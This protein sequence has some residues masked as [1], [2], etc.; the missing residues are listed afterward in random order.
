MVLIVQDT[1]KMEFTRHPPKDAQCLNTPDRYGLYEHFLLAVTPKKLT[2]T[3]CERATYVGTT[4]T[5]ERGEV[6]VSEV[7]TYRYQGIESP[8]LDMRND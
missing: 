4:Q 2:P 8:S 1:P 3:G 5:V 7:P 6:N